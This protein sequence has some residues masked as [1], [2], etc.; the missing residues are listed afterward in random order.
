MFK[1]N[2]HVKINLNLLDQTVIFIDHD[3]VVV[4]VRQVA[5]DPL[6]HTAGS[7]YDHTHL[8][9]IRTTR[10]CVYPKRL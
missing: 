2:A 7:T 9:T 3:D 5:G 6:P 4:L 10:R 1:R 8:T